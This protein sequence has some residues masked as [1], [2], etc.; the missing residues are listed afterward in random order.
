LEVK[1]IRG[2]TISGVVV[3][4]GANDPA[5][6]AK[7][8]QMGVAANIVS[9]R[10][11]DGQIYSGSGINSKIGDDGG[12][13]LTGATPGMARFHLSGAQAQAF[14][15]KR[16]ER[17][18]AEI[19]SAFEI[20]RGEQITGLRIVIAHADGTIRGHVEVA[21]GKPPEGWEFRIMADPIRTTA[22]NDSQPAFDSGGR[23]AAADGKGRFIIE[24]LTSGE[25]ELTLIPM[26]RVSQNEWTD[27]PGVTAV[28]R[29][30]A[31]SN[32]VETTVIFTLDPT[33]R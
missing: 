32:G 16:I 20:K 30:V 27:A 1:A 13:R 14:S 29:R 3:L 6:K 8:Q 17:G 12:F 7:L 19:R 4:E 24:R 33:R 10:G 22:E 25:Y 2:S 31:V 28:K 5:V 26:V 11:M 9:N 15:I 18:G 23:G 21:G